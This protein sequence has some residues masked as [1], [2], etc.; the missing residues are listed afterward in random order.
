MTKEEDVPEE[1]YE[2][3]ECPICGNTENKIVEHLNV[4]HKEMELSVSRISATALRCL[5]CAISFGIG[6]LV[7]HDT[8]CCIRSKQFQHVKERKLQHPKE[9]TGEKSS[10]A[11]GGGGGAANGI[12]FHPPIPEGI[13]NSP[14]DKMEH[15][16][17]LTSKELL[18]K[19]IRCGVCG[20]INSKLATVA[21]CLRSHG[22][23][24]CALCLNTYSDKNTYTT[25]LRQVHTLDNGKLK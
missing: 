25:H 20:R 5:K 21:E 10:P 8:Y 14:V 12:N 23:Y 7:S 2:P 19:A 3:A 15:A 24:R 18:R 22:I 13:G 4:A 11:S 1:E 9:G 16:A 17:N 6:D